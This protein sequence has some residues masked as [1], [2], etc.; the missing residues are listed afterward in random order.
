MSTGTD[1]NAAHH[2]LGDFPG[3]D[4]VEK[5]LRDLNAGDVTVE[6][7]L[8]ALASRRM[9]DLGLPV[10]AQA[11]LP[12]DPEVRLYRLLE[13]EDEAS[14]YGKYNSLKR[15]LVSFTRAME[16]RAVEALTRG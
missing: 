1:K 14:A 11:A 10:P 5:G 7:C 3:G 16:Q 13:A 12:G 9:R 2:N 4:L 6:A 15:R 8:V